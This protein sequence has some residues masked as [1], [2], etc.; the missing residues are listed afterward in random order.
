MPVHHVS[1][2]HLPKKNRIDKFPDLVER[3]RNLLLKT[4][5]PFT[6]ENV[7]GAPL[8]KDIILCGEM[9]GIRVLRHRI[10]EIEGFNVSQPQHI[11]HR[12]Q[13]SKDKSY[14]ASV[15][16]HGGDSV[17]FQTGRLAESNGC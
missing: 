11:K 13:I 6:I 16:G 3:I 7:V 5:K 9:F 12:P 2:I 8:R 14:Y 17:F 15:A 10:F 1:I 4:G